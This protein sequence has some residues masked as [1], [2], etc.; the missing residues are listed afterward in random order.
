MGWGEIVSTYYVALL[1][2]P[3]K[4]DDDNDDE[5]YGAVDGMVTGKENRG[6]PEK[7]C[8]SAPVQ[9]DVTWIE[10]GPPH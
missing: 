2:R 7:T 3:R 5:E 10:P 9:R 6:T 4:I 1:Y 8:P